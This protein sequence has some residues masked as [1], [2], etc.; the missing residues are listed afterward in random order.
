MQGPTIPRLTINVRETFE[1]AQEVARTL[2]QV[3]EIGVFHQDTPLFS[4]SVLPSGDE[5][6]DLPARDDTT[7]ATPALTETSAPDPAIPEAVKSSKR[8]SNLA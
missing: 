6:P 2:C 5:W 8:N 1:E 4:P 3:I 7:H